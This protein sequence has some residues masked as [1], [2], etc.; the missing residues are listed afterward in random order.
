[1]ENNK[2]ILG[3][4]DVKNS[5][6][7]IFENKFEINFSEEYIERL[8]AID[9]NN[10]GNAEVF[11]AM[12]EMLN[13]ILNDKEAY[14]KIK[15]SYEDHEKKEFGTM[16]IIKVMTFIFNEYSKEIASIKCTDFGSKN[17]YANRQQRRY[18]NRGYNKGY[19]NVYRR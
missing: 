11:G 19:N 6:I 3:F 5:E 16:I 1:M 9:V 17:L 2:R 7:E 13:L 4:E 8:R 14:N 12:K 15:K 10:I 18:N